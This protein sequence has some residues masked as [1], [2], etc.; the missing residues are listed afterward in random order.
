MF[1]SQKVEVQKSLEVLMKTTPLLTSY[2][3]EWSMETLGYL[4]SMMDLLRV[5]FLQQML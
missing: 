2:H 3:M 1:Q 5:F 4:G